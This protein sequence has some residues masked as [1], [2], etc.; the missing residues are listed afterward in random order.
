MPHLAHGKVCH[1]AL[2]AADVEASARFFEDV[3]GWRIRRRASSVTFDDAVGEVS[4]HFVPDRP[5]A[6]PGVLVYLW[7]DDLSA[8]VERVRHAGGS[9]EQPPGV[10]PGEQTAWFRDPACNVLG[11]Y[12]EPITP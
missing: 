1:I 2:P 12:Q 8:A 3:F 6:A 11:L 10:D 9:I 5:P 4:G 7:V